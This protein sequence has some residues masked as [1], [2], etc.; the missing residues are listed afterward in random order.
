MEYCPSVLCDLSEQEK[1]VNS[2]RAAT[3]W[4]EQNSDVCQHWE[5]QL[6]RKVQTA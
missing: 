1:S 3:T 5:Q 2:A 4:R 6:C